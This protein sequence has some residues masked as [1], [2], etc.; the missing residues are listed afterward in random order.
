[1]HEQLPQSSCSFLVMEKAVKNMLNEPRAQ[2]GFQDI[3]E[4]EKLKRDMMRSDTEKFQLF[5]KMLRRNNILNKAN[6]DIPQK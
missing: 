2:Y 6:T 3:S 1:M 5:T 4:D